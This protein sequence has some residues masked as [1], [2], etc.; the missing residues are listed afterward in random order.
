MFDIHILVPCKSYYI[1]FKKKKCVNTN[2]FYCYLAKSKFKF[3]IKKKEVKTNK[4][5]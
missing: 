3:I 1:I 5:K 4:Y 2:I